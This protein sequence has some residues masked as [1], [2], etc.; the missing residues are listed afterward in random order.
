MLSIFI[1]GYVLA[2]ESKATENNEKESNE[3]VLY[4][5][6][7]ADISNHKESSESIQMGIEL[8]FDEIGNTIEGYKVAFKYLDHRGNVIRSKRNYQTF[9]N[10]PNALAIY[11]GVHS[12]PLIKNR[13]FINQNGALTIVPWAAGGPV[14]RYPSK[15]NWV[16]RLSVDDTRA[17]P[18]IIDFAINNMGCKKPHL[19]LEDTP[20][21]DS[22]LESMSKALKHHNIDKPD[23]IRFSWN[24]KQKGARQLLQDIENDNSD[25]IVLVANAVEGAVIIQ[26]VV[27]LPKSR[28]LPILSHWGITGGN[29]HEKVTAEEREKIKLFFIQSCFS[30]TNKKQTPLAKKVFSHLKSYSKNKI[31]KPADLKAAPGFIHAYDATKILIQAIRQAGLTGNVKQDRAA[32]R[33][34]LENIKAPVQGLVKNYTKPFSVFD[35]KSNQNAHEALHKENYCMGSYGTADEVLLNQK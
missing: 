12:P 24:L 30:F 19:L 4:I 15:E 9:L 33:L 6:Q 32:I 14:T 26:E 35:E 23:V 5:Y 1:G 3:K 11:S 31:N 27:D 22:N 10:D 25:C 13:S 7:D 28:R 21:G 8:A 2:E 34:A 18:V 17:G 16:F 29:F 20:W